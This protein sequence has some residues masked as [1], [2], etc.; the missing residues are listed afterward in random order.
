MYHDLVTKGAYKH[1]H[2]LHTVSSATKVRSSEEEQRRHRNIWYNPHT[3]QQRYFSYIAKNSSK[4]LR[5]YF[6][7]DTFSTKYSTGTPSN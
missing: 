6:Q 2:S 7:K 1:Q 4:L 5:K 3:I